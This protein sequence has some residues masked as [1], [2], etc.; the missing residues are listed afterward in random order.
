MLTL[1]FMNQMYLFLGL[2]HLQVS[3]TNPIA[4]F[5]ASLL[6]PVLLGYLGGFFLSKALTGWPLEILFQK[7]ET[8]VLGKPISLSGTLLPG[9][10]MTPVLNLAL[11][12]PFHQMLNT[13]Y[14]T[15]WIYGTSLWPLTLPRLVRKMYTWFPLNSRSPT[16]SPGNS[17]FQSAFNV[18]TLGAH[19][20]VF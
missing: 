3:K 9:Q 15:Q 2:N 11:N 20:K 18:S 7:K 4:G 14:G 13:S 10:L 19:I 5:V 17:P 6:H 8:L 12:I 16:S 1:S